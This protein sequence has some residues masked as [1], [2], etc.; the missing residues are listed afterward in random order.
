VAL[1]AAALGGCGGEEDADRVLARTFGSAPAIRSAY[2]DLRLEVRGAALAGL[3]APLGVRLAGPFAAG[4]A[5]APARFDLRLD[6]RTHGGRARLGAIATGGRAWL[7]VQDTA[8]TLPAPL[9]RALEHGGAASEGAR[10]ARRGA[11]GADEGARGALRALGIDP[12]RWLRDPRAEGGEEL[13]GEPVTRVT[14]GVDVARLLADADT[15]LRRGGGLRSAGAPVP[16]GI[17]AATRRALAR[18]MRDARVEIWSRERDGVLRRIALVAGY[19]RA[20]RK[21]ELRLALDLQ[22]VNERQP[23][24]PPARARPVAELRA[25]LAQL[26]ATLQRHRAAGVAGAAGDGY[27]RCLADAAGDLARAQRCAALLGQ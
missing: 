21:G 4:R 7:L 24:G 2:V 5:G 1:A 9:A 18:S 26:A 3:P 27:E 10:G 20:G 6:V 14:A 11:G 15:L 16:A 19:E 8:Y 22:A 12:R 17:P 13:D 25:A 23:I